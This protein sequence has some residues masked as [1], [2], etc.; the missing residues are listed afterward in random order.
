M[1][2][3]RRTPRP[4]PHFPRG[5]FPAGGCIGDEES[6]PARARA[7]TSPGFAPSTPD[8]PDPGCPHLGRDGK[9]CGVCWSCRRKADGPEWWLLG[10]PYPK[11]RKR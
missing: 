11:A 9:P 8:L 6:P 4:T 7:K 10:P 5:T 3:A 2:R 1:K